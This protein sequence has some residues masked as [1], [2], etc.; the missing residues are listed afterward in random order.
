MLRAFKVRFIERNLG[1]I[2]SFGALSLSE[3]SFGHD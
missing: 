1:S 3:K 2:G